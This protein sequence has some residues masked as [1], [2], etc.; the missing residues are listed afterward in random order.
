MQQLHGL[1]AVSGGPVAHEKMG[2]AKEE[3]TAR[4]PPAAPRERAHGEEEQT[5]VRNRGGEGAEEAER[6]RGQAHAEDAGERGAEGTPAAERQGGHALEEGQRDAREETGQADPG[7]GGQEDQET[8]G[9]DRPCSTDADR[10][11][12]GRHGR[13][14]GRHEPLSV[15][16][17]DARL[18]HR[19]RSVHEA[20]LISQSPSASRHGDAEPFQA[21][22]FPAASQTA[23]LNTVKK[24]YFKA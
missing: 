21:G 12:P 20:A 10:A 5:G 22:L 8:P 2:S 11:R 15:P 14:H 16:L 24:S 1:P 4:S 6:P 7:E 23:L 17:P 19:Q 18:L 9:E 3:R 13:P